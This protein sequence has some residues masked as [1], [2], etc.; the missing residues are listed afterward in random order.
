MHSSW[1]VMSYEEEDTCIHLGLC[2]DFMGDNHDL[3][4]SVFFTM[5]NGLFTG[6]E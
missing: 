1:S 6:L 5:I 4:R 3:F 2:A